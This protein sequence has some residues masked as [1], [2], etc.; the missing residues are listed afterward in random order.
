MNLVKLS[1]K[2]ITINTLLLKGLTKNYR[3]SFQTGLNIIAGPI[4]TGKTSM[5]EF[6]DYCLGSSS[7]PE[8]VEIQKR[9]FAAF[10][11]LTIDGKTVVIERPLFSTEQRAKIHVCKLE[12]LDEK[13]E[14]IDIR[15]RQIPGQESI[16]SFM[17]KNLNLFNVFIKEAPTKDASN[18]DMMSFRDLMWFC[19]LNHERLDNKELLFENIWM[20]KLKLQQV[21]DV[22]FGVHDNELNSLSFQLK[23]LLNQKSELEG[24]IRTLTEFFSERKLPSIVELQEKLKTLSNQEL[25]NSDKLSQITLVLR[26]KSDVA[27][28]MREQLSHDNEELNILLSQKRDRETLLKRLLPLRGQYSEDEKKMRFLQESKEIIDPLA[29]VIC[30]FCLQDISGTP[31]KNVCKV[32]GRH[33]NNKPQDSFDISKEITTLHNKLHD[34]NIYVSE[35]TA[36][37]EI[38]EESLKEKRQK[39]NSISTRIDES[40][41]QFVSPYMAE[42]DAIVGQLNRIQ[43]EIQDTR[44]NLK[45]YES[46]EKRIRKKVELERDLVFVQQ[47]LESGRRQKENRL[48]IIDKVS[49]RYSEILSQVKLPKLSDAYIDQDLLPHVRGLEYKKIGSSG[50]LT[51]L[52][53][54]WFLSIF[55]ISMESEST[56]PGFVMIDH[57]Q[58]NI[59]IS[60]QAEEPEYHDSK[61]VEGLYEHLIKKANEYG[62][63]AQ[64]II[65]DNEPPS[66]AE[67]YVRIKFSR[68]R[69]KPPYG[70]IDDE[71]E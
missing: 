8:H 43:Q 41:K 2:H 39:I 56:H 42:R 67:K 13:H 35:T 1:N 60:A 30:P 50:S 10:L 29:I 34:L 54:S 62:D 25:G 27:Q 11:E 24:E 12:E 7:H 51:L 45:L 19:Y 31:E 20:K 28:E 69:N 57:P 40:M 14:L 3:Y 47:K 48:L 46:I 32:C 5:L 22:I 68:N 49:E 70:L 71:V 53:V 9:V 66:I 26:G 55:E 37:L 23:G 6:I 16:S 52:S 58:K 61:I 4:A 33:L 17:L 38:I 15:S 59:G 65:V 63:T 18:Q 44:D 36:E 64:W 21:F